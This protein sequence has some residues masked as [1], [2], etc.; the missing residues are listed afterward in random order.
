VLDTTYFFAAV[1]RVQLEVR[2]AV[3]RSNSL[4]VGAL[5]AARIT[6]HQHFHCA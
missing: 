4:S 1:D 3:P 5:S 2:Q 6:E